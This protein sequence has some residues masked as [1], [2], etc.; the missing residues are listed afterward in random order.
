MFTK[1]RQAHDRFRWLPPAAIIAAGFLVGAATAESL[2][3]NIIEDDDEDAGNTLTTAAKAKGTG[4]TIQS[5]AGTLTGNGGGFTAR[6]GEEGDFQDLWLIYI[7]DPA[8]FSAS[9]VPGQGSATFDTRLFL[10]RADGRGLLYANDSQGSLQSF[11][12]N[13]A[14]K[15][16]I[17]IDAPGIYCLGIT[18]NPVQPRTTLNAPMF[19]KVG[20]DGIAGATIAGQASPLEGWAPFAGATGEYVIR[21]TGVKGIPANCGDGG[22]CYRPNLG[23]GCDDLDCCTLIG[24]LDPYCVTSMWDLQCANLARAKCFSCG[25]PSAG[26]CR[27]VSP[28]PY[29]ED[30][31][32]CEVVCDTDPLCCIEAWDADCV[33]IASVSCVDPC[34]PDCPE[35]FNHDG[36]RDGADLGVLL[37]NWSQP[38]C[39]DLNHDGTTDGGDLG[40][41]LGSPNCPKC[42][43]LDSGGCFVAKNSPGCDE[44][45]CCQIVCDSDPVC[46]QDAW[47]NACVG[48]AQELCASACGNPNA[49]ACLSS[50]PSPGCDDPICCTEVCNVLPRCCVDFWD[51]VCVDYAGSVPDCQP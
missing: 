5:I 46:C 9:T 20:G 43:L 15:G 2:G 37:G 51:Q 31:A 13:E 16:D 34:N 32:C 50:H 3:P 1:M 12:G 26:D 36:I 29:C 40:L 11:L 21:L 44:A 4:G 30:G 42:G 8:A 18:G 41:F 33:G 14:T 24:E 27:T 38:G 49:G 48:L 39:T 35:D 25:A 6:S 22:D 23:P 19:P 45:S 10:F 28:T 7:D 47:D 17:K